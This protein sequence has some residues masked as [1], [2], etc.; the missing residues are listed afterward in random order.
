MFAGNYSVNL[1][2]LNSCGNSN[3][4]FRSITVNGTVCPDVVS[5][6]S[7]NLSSGE[8]PLT[9]SFTD[10]STGGTLSGWNWSFGDGNVSADPNPVHT[11][12]VAGNYSVNLSSLN[13]CGNSNSSFR[14]I[15]VNGT[16][17]PDVVSNFSSNVSSGE[18]PLTVS[19]TDSSTGGTLSGWNWSFGDG[20]VSADPNPVHT[21]SIAGNYSVNLSSLNS[22]G[23]S[24]SSFRSITVNG[25]VCPD[26]VSNFSSNVSSGEVPL[27][28]SFTD[29]STGGTLSGWNW[30]FGDG[31][32]SADPNPVHT[33]SVAGNYSVNL[34]SLNSCGNSNSSFRSIT[35]NGTV[36]PDVVSNFSSNVSSGEVPLTVSFTDS[37]TG[38]TL[39]GWNWSFGD[40]TVSADPN[41]VHTFSV[42][43][44]YSVNLSS[45]NS[46][47][48]SN[49]SF[50]SITVNGTVCPDVVSNF[51]SNVSSGEVPLT[52]SFT[53]SS[54]GGYSQRMELELWRW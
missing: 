33:F 3:S 37:S 18:V 7:S 4:S 48:N 45:L 39:S 50:R 31:N 46:C 1:S 34:S 14:S 11:F 27:T 26:V 28:V 21:F 36:C 43:G 15:T 44:N 51:S 29:S 42:A 2:S 23:N 16:V 6:F 10:S 5:N 17:C 49:S 8:V 47:G 20:T 41:P 12:S 40:G 22:C 52:V 53:D 19:F 32:V 38:G 25:T 13:S 30:S 9:V 24:N 35:V 54:T